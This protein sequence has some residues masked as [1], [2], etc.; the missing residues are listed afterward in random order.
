MTVAET[1][2]N[3]AV[4]L[5][6]RGT[7]SFR[8]IA[9]ECESR[10]EVIVHFLA[11]LEL[12]KQG[13]IELEQVTTFGEMTLQ[14]RPDGPDADGDF[15]DRAWIDRSEVDEKVDDGAVRADRSR[16]VDATM[17]EVDSYDG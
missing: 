3:L 17:G 13:W 12:Y 11:V 2:T 6:G 15:V 5:A 10:V 4:A 7:V 16:L 8:E 14:W 1:V 9:G